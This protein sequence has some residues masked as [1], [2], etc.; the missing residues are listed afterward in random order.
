MVDN[1]NLRILVA[2]DERPIRESY[3]RIFSS[4]SK[5]AAVSEMEVLEAELYSKKG[6][7]SGLCALD[8]VLCSQ[9]EDAVAA[10]AQARA[11]GKPFSVVF[12]DVRMP[13]GIDGVTAAKKIRAID[14]DIVI[15]FI[16]GFSDV[17]PAQIEAAVPPSEKILYLQKPVQ[18]AEIQQLT[19][20]LVSQWKLQKTLL[21][22]IAEIEHENATLRRALNQLQP[23][24]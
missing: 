1:E 6:T 13:P 2:D 11:D 15:V 4:I 19:R 10:V 24:R 8:V 22:R 16:T 7:H 21:L 5:H 23:A 17:D 18:T 12:L 20:T 9:G 14:M 3:E